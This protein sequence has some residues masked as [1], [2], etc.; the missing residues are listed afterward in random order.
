[1]KR[2]LAVLLSAMVLSS[3]AMLSGCKDNGNG[4]ATESVT[5]SKSTNNAVA[6]KEKFA[7]L[8]AELEAYKSQPKFN[9]TKYIDAKKI[10][11]N[12]KIAVISDSNNNTYSSYISQELKSVAKEVGF[13]DVLIY[14]TDGTSNSHIS[15]LE[16]AVSDQCSAVILIG[17]INKDKISLSIETAQA[18]GLKIISLDNTQV[19]TKDHF[20][21]SSITTDYAAEAKALADYAIV[22][23]EGKVNALLVTPSDVSYADEIKKAVTDELSKY[24]DGYCTELSIESSNTAVNISDAVKK[25]LERDT[26]INCVIV[27]H[28]NML[29]DSVDALEMTQAISRVTLLARGGSTELFTQVQ[30][31]NVATAISESYEWTAYNA[32]DYV[33]RVLNGEDNPETPNIPFMMI[34]YDNV[35]KLENSENS[36]ESSSDEESSNEETNDDTPL[37]EKM[38]TKTFKKQYLNLWGLGENSEDSQTE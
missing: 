11:K 38:F 31:G 33:L 28:D 3:V 22:E 24:S 8:S 20:V 29:K 30:N 1:M 34:S 10:S 12:K 9:A 15:A 16:N 4:S 2:I 7:T 23:K 32:V 27:L 35:K 37:I 17:N 6:S 25:A 21:D 14:D 36:T 13:K 19:G 18:N 5:E 26:N